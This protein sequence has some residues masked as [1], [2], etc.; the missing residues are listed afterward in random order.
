MKEQIA[1]FL[2]YLRNHKGR[3]EATLTSYQSDLEKFSENMEQNGCV[4]VDQITRVQLAAYFNGLFQAGRASASVTRASVSLRSFF[5]YLAMQRLIAYDPMISVELPKVV[6]NPPQI[7]SLEEVKRL[8][9]TPDAST[10]AGLRDQ[11][12]LELLYGTGL[13]V[14]EL[15]ALRVSDVDLFLKF[16]RPAEDTGKERIVPFGETTRH[17]LEAYLERGRPELANP[18]S[19]ALFVSR[20]GDSMSRQAFWKLMKKVAAEAN[21]STEITPHTLRH[22]FASHLLDSGA[23]LRSV[24]EMLGHTAPISTQAYLSKSKESLRTVYQ[25]HHPRAKPET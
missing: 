7:L 15:I 21:I 24:Q 5:R 25:H 6:K 8:L 14:S 16:V 20:F 1:S 3:S 10:S 23:D 12:M 22:S 13:R 19:T 9:S 11:A 4:R 2:D 17:K 18:E